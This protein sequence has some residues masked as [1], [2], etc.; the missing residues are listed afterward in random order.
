MRGGMWE[1][2]VCNITEAFRHTMR[3]VMGIAD[4]EPG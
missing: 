2:L 4:L 3:E 1:D